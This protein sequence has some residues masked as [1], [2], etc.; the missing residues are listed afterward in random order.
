VVQISTAQ[1]LSRFRSCVVFLSKTRQVVGYYFSYV[2]NIFLQ[3]PTSY[4]F[5]VVGILKYRQHRKTKEQ[6]LLVF[7]DE[8][9]R[10]SS[11]TFATCHQASW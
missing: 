5:T 10:K 8:D 11:E 2:T 1:C 3:I 7:A 9:L 6:R 4:S